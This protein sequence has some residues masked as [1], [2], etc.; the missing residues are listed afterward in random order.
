MSK[1]GKT[2]VVLLLVA[3]GGSYLARKALTDRNSAPELSDGAAP[4]PVAAPSPE[5]IISLAPSVTEVLFAL[6]LGDRV[7]GVTR[8]CTY[9]PEAAAKAEIGGFFDPNY[10]AIVALE[11]DLAVLFPVHGEIQD[12]LHDLGIETLIVD[13]RTLEG[14]LDSIRIAG[15]ACGASERAEELLAGIQSRIERITEKTQGLER[16]RVL[17]SAGRNLGS[18]RLEEVYAAG[19]HMWYD[20]LIAYAG[21]VNAFEDE[22]VQFPSLSGEGLLWLDPDVIIEMAPDLDNKPYGRQDLIDEWSTLDDLAA[23]R[24]HRVHVL[25]GDYVTIPGPRFIRT[26]EDMAE[27]IHPELDWEAP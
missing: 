7:C 6:G 17:L 18:G 4:S 21:G 19:K 25:G 8:Y 26:L 9:P 5:R 2:L 24:S 23:V 15:R 20:D 1:A 22:T 10:E 13:H 27:A 16:P 12:R 3:F 11:P 14:I